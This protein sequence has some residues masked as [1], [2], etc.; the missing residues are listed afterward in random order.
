M[1]IKRLELLGKK[2]SIKTAI[3]FFE[4]NPGA[5]NPGTRVVLVMPVGM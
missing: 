3:E 2:F 4:T 5:V 1:T